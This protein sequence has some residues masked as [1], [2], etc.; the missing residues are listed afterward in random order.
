MTPPFDRQGQ[1]R[2][3][4]SLFPVTVAGQHSYVFRTLPPDWDPKDTGT[5]AQR[6]RLRAR[7]G[8]GTWVTSPWLI[9]NKGDVDW[10][11]VKRLAGRRRIL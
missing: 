3:L 1:P 4:P 10:D 7:L 9:V 5:K 8:S 11:E 6:V 2:P